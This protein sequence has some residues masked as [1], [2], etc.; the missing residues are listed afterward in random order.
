MSSVERSTT[1]LTRGSASSCAL[2]S[3]LRAAPLPGA[4]ITIR[5]VPPVSLSSLWARGR[6]PPGATAN[7]LRA[8]PV[9][10][11]GGVAPVDEVLRARDEARVVAEQEHHKLRDLV[12]VAQAANRVQ[13]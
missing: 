12:R 6:S 1:S 8:F 11:L 9:G 10:L 4:P 5:I 13:V 2:S 7:V 3:F